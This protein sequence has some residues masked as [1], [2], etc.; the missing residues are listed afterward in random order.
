MKEPTQI[1]RGFT[2]EQWKRLRKRLGGRDGQIYNDE[3]A[4]GCAVDV[5][6]RRMRERF[7][8]CIEALE[9]ADSQLEKEVAPGAPA[10]CSTLPKDNGKRIV[11]PG[12][13]VVALCCLLIETLQ[14]FREAPEQPAQVV[15]PCSY[16][17]GRCI[18]LPSSTRDLFIKFLQLP[19]FHGEFD[20]RKIAKRFVQGIRNGILHEAETRRWLIWR[21]EPQGR[22]VEPLGN[23]YALNRTGFYR[24]LKT[25]FEKYLQ[26]LRDPAKQQ[27]RERFVKKMDDVVREC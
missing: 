3:T 9:K 1:C 13:A 12:F 4:W 14:S 17:R 8:S 18:R 23:R 24:A 16:P 22:I 25:E 15:G 20:D 7:L 10:E 6:E 26:E 2:D 19:A 27:Q 5:F 11:V 21:G